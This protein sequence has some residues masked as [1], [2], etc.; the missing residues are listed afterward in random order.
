M[1]D[2]QKEIEKKFPNMQKKDTFLKKSFV[3]FI[4]S[5][6]VMLSCFVVMKSGYDR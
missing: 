1:I 5:V 2:I 4:R 3:R 6:E